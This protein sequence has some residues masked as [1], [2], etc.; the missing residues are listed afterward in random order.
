MEPS[1]N[2]LDKERLEVIFSQ[3][4]PKQ[5]KQSKLFSALNR[6]WQYLLTILTKDINE[7]Q[8]WQTSD[9]LGNTRWNA[10]EPTTGRFT[11]LATDAEMRAWIEE[12]YYQR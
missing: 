12:R 3:S 9:R 8:V 1:T 7:L 5:V 10:Y 6:I 4:E 11:S 2:Y